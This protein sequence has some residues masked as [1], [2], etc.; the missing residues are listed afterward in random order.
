MKMRIENQDEEDFVRRVLFVGSAKV[1]SVTKDKA[2]GVMYHFHAMGPFNID[3]ARD[4]LSGLMELSVI[5][6]ELR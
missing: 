2:H 3:E 1:A 6:E 5:A 4:W